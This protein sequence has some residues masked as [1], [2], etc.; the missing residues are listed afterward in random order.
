MKKFT[1]LL[2]VMLLISGCTTSSDTV[3]EKPETNMEQGQTD[4]NTGGESQDK[5]DADGKD[6]KNVD[7]YIEPAQLNEDEGN[8]LD[9]IGI[10][11]DGLICDFAVDENVESVY[12]TVYKYKDGTW[13]EYTRDSRLFG[14]EEG[15]IALVYEDMGNGMRV[16]FQSENDRGNTEFYPDTED[17][18]DAGRM[19]SKLN[20]RKTVEYNEEIPVAIQVYTGDE[21]PS[22]VGLESFFEPESLKG[23]EDAYVITL[24]FSDLNLDEHRKM[25][26]SEE[27]MKEEPVDKMKKE[28]AE[29]EKIDQNVQ[30]NQEEQKDQEAT[31]QEQAQRAL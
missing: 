29:E 3:E 30:E 21:G 5:G 27:K 12:I 10:D 31:M 15:R 4:E 28:E 16:S 14:D 18:Y 6:E 9:L 20:V 24:E 17:I 8:I 13:K 23:C 1:M 11:N 7:M 25:K 22:S 2:A 19:Q 26:E